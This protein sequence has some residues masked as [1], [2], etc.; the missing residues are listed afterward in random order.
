MQNKPNVLAKCKVIII[1]G[2]AIIT[3]PGMRYLHFLGYFLCWPWTLADACGC[4]N[5]LDT[6][7]E[8]MKAQ[9]DGKWT[10]QALP[11]HPNHVPTIPNHFPIFANRFD[12]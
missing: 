11:T 8:T 12:I 2:T 10:I 1:V 9:S 3:T 7:M 4:S 6:L 5:S